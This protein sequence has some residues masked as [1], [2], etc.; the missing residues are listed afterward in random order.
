MFFCHILARGMQRISRTEA[1]S[2]SAYSNARSTGI[3]GIGSGYY[4]IGFYVNRHVE[5][6]GSIEMVF[7]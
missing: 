5:N 6:V 7:L 3:Y 2:H 4:C 1:E